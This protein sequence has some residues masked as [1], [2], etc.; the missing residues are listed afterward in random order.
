MLFFIQ[1]NLN[2]QQSVKLLKQWEQHC[3]L[4]TAHGLLNIYGHVRS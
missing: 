3:H 2:V 4:Q 1:N